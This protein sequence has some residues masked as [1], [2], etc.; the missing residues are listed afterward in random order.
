M[1]WSTYCN[2]INCNPVTACRMFENRVQAFTSK[3]IMSLSQPI[4]EV[5]D[6]FLREFKKKRSA[7]YP[8]YF[9]CKD[10]PLFDPDADDQ[11]TFTS[12]V[13]KYISCS[14]PGEKAKPELYE[15]VTKLQ[16][17]SKTH[18]STCARPNTACRF[19]FSSTSC[20]PN[21]HCYK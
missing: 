2:I 10:A 7:T 13:D 5:M 9:W 18:S 11:S 17:H 8:L 6:H 3:V 16:Q 14:I 21:I 20:R 1:D 19:G 15:L 12:F 4:R